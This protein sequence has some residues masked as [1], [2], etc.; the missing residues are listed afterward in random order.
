ML[1]GTRQLR[2]IVNVGLAY[3]DEVHPEDKLTRRITT[4]NDF[5]V[6]E[7]G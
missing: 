6:L 2:V 5:E 4:T 3:W 7:R 1:A